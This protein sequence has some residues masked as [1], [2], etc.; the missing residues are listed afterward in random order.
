MPLSSGADRSLSRN[1]RSCLILPQSKPELEPRSFSR[2]AFRFRFQVWSQI[3]VW[4]I[5]YKRNPSRK[6]FQVKINPFPSSF[7]RN[8]IERNCIWKIFLKLCKESEP[9]QEK[10]EG[11]K[12]SKPEPEPCQNGT[13]ATLPVRV[14]CLPS[15]TIFKTTDFTWIQV[16]QEGCL[17]P[18]VR[19]DEAYPSVVD[20]GATKGKKL[21][22]SMI[23]HDFWKMDKHSRRQCYGSR[24]FQVISKLA[25]ETFYI[26]KYR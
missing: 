4:Y 22:S 10:Y 25:C 18:R 5:S 26:N 20:P 24:E 12:N 7:N 19:T 9:K 1:C 21:Y 14:Q 11:N 15:W 6:T 16:G 13:V 17:G 3:R 23:F 2:F 8:V